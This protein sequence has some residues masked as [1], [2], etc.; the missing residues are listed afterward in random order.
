MEN[1]RL[2]DICDTRSGHL[3]REKKIM[4]IISIAN[5]ISTF[6]IEDDMLDWHLCQICYSLEI[7]IL[8]LF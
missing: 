8:L 1:R 6:V 5:V 7:K 4:I 3:T 2:I